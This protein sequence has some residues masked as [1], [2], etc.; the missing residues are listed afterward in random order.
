MVIAR[1][2]LRLCGPLLLV[3]LVMTNDV[4]GIWALLRT[5]NLQL[6]FIAVLLGFLLLY[7][8]GVRWQMILEG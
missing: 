1:W 8:K 7:L 2:L 5:T 4:S 3:L 6:M